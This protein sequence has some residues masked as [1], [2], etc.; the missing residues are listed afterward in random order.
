MVISSYLEILSW[1]HTKKKSALTTW[2]QSSQMDVLSTLLIQT[3]AFTQLSD[4]L[5]LS[6]WIMILILHN[7]HYGISGFILIR[8]WFCYSGNLIHES[9][10]KKNPKNPNQP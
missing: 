6:Q 3:E 5:A 2:D 9:R 4:Y 8:Y 1:K 7:T 10:G